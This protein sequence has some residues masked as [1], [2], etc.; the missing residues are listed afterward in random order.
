M[1]EAKRRADASRSQA[2][3]V[4]LTCGERFELRSI[5]LQRHTKDDAVMDRNNDAIEAL[6]G[7]DSFDMP[8]GL[9]EDAQQTWLR[10]LQARLDNQDR[11]W[12][13][14]TIENITTILDAIEWCAQNGLVINQKGEKVVL[15]DGARAYRIR[16]AR[17]RLKAARSDVPILG[18]AEPARIEVPAEPA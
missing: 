11:A 3:N 7:D 14:L 10:S 9:R 16:H 5:L 13:S 1:G 12:V 18:E 6:D 2:W 4:R 8:G 17:K 15:M